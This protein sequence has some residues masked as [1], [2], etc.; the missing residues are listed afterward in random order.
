MSKRRWY[1]ST[2]GG[3]SR[4]R[5]DGQTVDR[6]VILSNGRCKF[7]VVRLDAETT[8]FATN[9]WLVWEF[10]DNVAQAKRRMGP[11]RVQ[12][13]IVD[14]PRPICPLRRAFGV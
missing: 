9:D 4:Q 2:Q 10:A 1:R 6:I 14:S 7:G 5:S 12:A 8:N 3:F 11:R 13:P